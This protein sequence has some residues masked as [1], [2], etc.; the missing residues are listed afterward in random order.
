MKL[1]ERWHMYSEIMRLKKMGLNISQISRHLNI[2]RNTVYQYK[3]LNPDEYNRILENMQTRRKKLDSKKDEILSWLKEFPDLSG[4]QVLDWVMERYPETNIS[5]GTARNYV[6]YLRKEYDIP[7]TI[8]KRD[9]EA[10]EDPAL[11]YQ[12]QVDFGEKKLKNAQGNLVKLWFI[13]FVL[14]NSRYKYVEWLDKPFNTKDVIRMHEN[15]FSFY[16]GRTKEIVYDQ[17]HLVLTSENGGDLI[18]THEFSNYT[19]K[20]GFQIYMCRKQDPESKGRV[21]NVVGFVKNNFAN[22]R[23]FFNLEKFNED[24]LAWLWRTGNGKLHNTTKKIPAEMFAL[25]KPHLLPVHEKIDI[26]CNTSITRIVRKDNTVWF[27]GNRYSVPLGTY[28]GTEKAV[29]VLEVPGNTLVINDP[30]T[31]QEL[32]RHSISLEKGRLIK[33]NNHGRDRSKG[34]NKYIETVAELFP[35]PLQA[36]EW[37][38]EIRA[39]KPRYIRDQL[40]AIQKSI[41][42]I[43]T[44]VTEKALNYCIDHS[45]FSATDFNNAVDYFNKL[46]PREGMDWTAPYSSVEIKPLNEIDRSK[47]ETRPMIRDFDYYKEFLERG[48][49]C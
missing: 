8:H 48:N 26:T 29:E 27:M 33:N 49:I 41:K 13:V 45:L 6:S 30:E 18:L 43:D 36:K 32:A 9:Y 46:Q 20:R 38:E 34:I 39:K 19:R 28:D 42:S 15:A 11:G 10:I 4:A 14:S 1:T 16:G 35:H 25:E 21:E 40:Q 7:K 23:I 44:I 12:L 5:E 2:S 31:K 3:D 24:C 22:H 47:L 17:D 37:L